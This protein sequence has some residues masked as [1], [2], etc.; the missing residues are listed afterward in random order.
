MFITR[1]CGGAWSGEKIFLA[2]AFFLLV[3]I[4]AMA[5][6]VPNPAAQVL[7]VSPYQAPGALPE[8]VGILGRARPEY[9][10]QGVSIGGFYL[11]PT[12]AA[13]LSSDD[14]VF[15][16]SSAQVSDLFWTF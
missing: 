13:S 14:N 1:R 11:Y 10:A 9:D 12:I 2:S 5:D 4:P 16:R 15:R 3:G 7:T 6:D 8:G